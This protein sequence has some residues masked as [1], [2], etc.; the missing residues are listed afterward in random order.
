M[1]EETTGGFLQP[2]QNRKGV[3]AEAPKEMFDFLANIE[4]LKDIIDLP[5]SE[6]LEKYS[7]YMTE[8]EISELKKIAENNNKVC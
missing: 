8:E 4:M 2:I 3:E 1:S 6:A 5:L 7:S